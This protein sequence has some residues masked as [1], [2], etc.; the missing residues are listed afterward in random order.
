MLDDSI[1]ELQAFFWWGQGDRDNI[2]DHSIACK[3][4]FFYTF[5]TFYFTACQIA[6]PLNQNILMPGKVQECLLLMMFLLE[7]MYRTQCKFFLKSTFISSLKIC[8]LK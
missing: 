5:V 3:E 2:T 1:K 4:L 7:I 8:P 6:H